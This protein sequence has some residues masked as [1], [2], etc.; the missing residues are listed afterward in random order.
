MVVTCGIY[1]CEA[2]RVTH[3]VAPS[4]R[5]RQA[6]SGHPSKLSSISGH[7]T[8]RSYVSGGV[9]GNPSTPYLRSSPHRQVNRPPEYTRVCAAF[10]LHTADLMTLPV[11]R[12]ERFLTP[13]HRLTARLA[14]AYNLT[15]CDNRVRRSHEAR[16]IQDINSTYNST[17]A[18]NPS[19]EDPSPFP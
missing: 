10:T 1:S 7:Y 16:E 3:S 17:L 9:G 11:P 13:T 4:I 12:Q 19:P 2:L 5:P 8:P 15:R 18:G 6:F 14:G